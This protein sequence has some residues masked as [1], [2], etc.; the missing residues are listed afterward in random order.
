[1][2]LLIRVNVLNYIIDLFLAFDKHSQVFSKKALTLG[3]TATILSITP[4]IIIKLV[5]IERCW[6]LSKQ[7]GALLLNQTG[8]IVHQGLKEVEYVQI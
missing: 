8:N 5:Y 7:L 4:L 1:M 3:V 2:S 6:Q